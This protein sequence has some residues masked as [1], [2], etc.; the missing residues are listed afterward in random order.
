MVNVFAEQALS[1]R[2][3][4]CSKNRWQAQGSNRLESCSL[5]PGTGERVGVRGQARVTLTLTLSLKG[6]GK[7]LLQSLRCRP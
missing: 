7:N 4:K 3:S 6:E 5:S 1:E 2:P